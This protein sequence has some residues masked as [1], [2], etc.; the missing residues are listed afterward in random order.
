MSEQQAD[1]PTDTQ[2]PPEPDGQDSSVDASETD[3]RSS[4]SSSSGSGDGDSEPGG[5]GDDQLP[6]DLQPSEDN[7]LA[8]HP[9]QTGNEDDK[10]GADTEG[11][12]AENPSTN[13]TYGNPGSDSSDSEEDGSDAP[14]E[15]QNSEV[16][17]EED[18]G[19]AT[20]DN[21]GGGAG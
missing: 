9:R 7:P 4:E 6:E 13:M 21:G 10:I 18:D 11:V 1:E 12:D 2:P 3:S 20:L 19:S 15:P 16:K 5:I 14:G 17:A 8:R